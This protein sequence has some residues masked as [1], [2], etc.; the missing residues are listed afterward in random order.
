[1]EQQENYVQGRKWDD[2]FWRYADLR[3]CPL[4]V[5]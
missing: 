4:F 1:M 2:R 5:G 3:A